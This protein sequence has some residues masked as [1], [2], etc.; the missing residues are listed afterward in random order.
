MVVRLVMFALLMLLRQRR[1]ALFPRTRTN[2]GGLM[3]RSTLPTT[4]GRYRRA[5]A[6]L[7]L[8][9]LPFTMAACSS[10]EPADDAEVVEESPAEE[11]PAEEAPAE[12]EDEG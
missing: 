12:E 2:N 3:S 11:E 1:G 10:D 5:A 6:A 9:T 7:L 8:A 4:S